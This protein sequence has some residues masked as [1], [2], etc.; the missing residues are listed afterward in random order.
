LCAWFSYRQALISSLALEKPEDVED[1]VLQQL[2]KLKSNPNM[3][4]R[5]YVLFFNLACPVAESTRL[6]LRAPG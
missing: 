2:Q 1:Y 4:V 3:L 5:W 6:M